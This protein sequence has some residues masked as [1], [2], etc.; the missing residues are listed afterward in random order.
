M[1]QGGPT[2]TFCKLIVCISNQCISPY[3]TFFIFFFAIWCNAERQQ[4]REREKQGR[5]RERT[6]ECTHSLHLPPLK[7]A[8][9]AK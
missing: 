8:D 6:P 3:H 7:S 9:A 2:F 1:W 4:E 5:D